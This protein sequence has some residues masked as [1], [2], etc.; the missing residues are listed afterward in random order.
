MWVSPNTIVIRAS[1]AASFIDKLKTVTRDKTEYFKSLSTPSQMFIYLIA[2][3][4]ILRVGLVMSGPCQA[5]L[6]HTV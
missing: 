6:K 2:Y 4:F 5:G 3:L 1:Q